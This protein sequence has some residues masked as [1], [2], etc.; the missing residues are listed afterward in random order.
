MRSNR[1]PALSLVYGDEGGFVIRDT[2][3]GGAGNFGISFDEFKDWWRLQKRVGNPTFDD[4]KAMPRSEADALYAKFYMD[5]AHFDDLA[6]G[7]DYVVLDGFIN[8]G[9]LTILQGALGFAESER[10]VQRH[11]FGPKTLWAATHR[12]PRALI[13]K[14][15]DVR[16]AR[17]K[18]LKL[19]T[20]PTKP[21]GKT[22]F[23]QVWDRRTELVRGRA[24]KMVA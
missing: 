14:L 5:P 4:L 11:V 13:N 23:G 18:T 16:L 9:G 3:P 20:R 8:G 22:T 7:V 1:A 10:E 12:D 6:S 21:G 2:E 17:N 24:L 15:C 19:Y